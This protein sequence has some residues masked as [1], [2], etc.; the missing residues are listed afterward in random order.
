MNSTSQLFMQQGQLKSNT[1][2]GN[3][4]T[5]KFEFRLLVGIYVYRENY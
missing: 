2:L 5:G 3:A 4:H 1:V